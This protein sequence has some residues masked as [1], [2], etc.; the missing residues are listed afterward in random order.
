MV[1]RASPPIRRTVPRAWLSETRVAGQGGVSFLSRSDLPEVRIRGRKIMSMY[2]ESPPARTFHE[3]R[4]APVRH[5][6]HHVTV[7]KP[8]TRVSRQDPGEVL[9]F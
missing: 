7:P 4:E 5:R 2:F 6:H 1:H 3:L 8:A 9:V